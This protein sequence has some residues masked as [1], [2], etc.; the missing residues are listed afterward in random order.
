MFCLAWFL[1]V[2]VHNPVGA[3]G[4]HTPRQ[5][6][7]H[8]LSFS[9]RFML[10]YSFILRKLA[11]LVCLVIDWKRTLDF[12]NGLEKIRSTISEF[13]RV[14]SLVHRVDRV[15]GTRCVR[16][17]LVRKAKSCKSDEKVRLKIDHHQDED[18]AFWRSVLWSDERR[19]WTVG[20]WRCTRGGF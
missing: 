16:S 18:P 3:K 9:T 17:P 8:N 5:K 7:F 6:K 4:L 12:G 19:N 1:A 15:G 10:S 20:P 11:H 2:V 14:K 13:Q